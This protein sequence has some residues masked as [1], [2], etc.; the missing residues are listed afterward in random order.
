MTVNHADLSMVTARVIFDEALDGGT[1]GGALV[2]EAEADA[3]PSDIGI[4]LGGER[5]DTGDGRRNCRTNSQ[6]F[7]GDSDSPGVAVSGSSDNREG[8]GRNANSAPAAGGLLAAVRW[9]GP[10]DDLEVD[11]SV[12]G[13]AGRGRGVAPGETQVRC[14]P[15]VGTVSREAVVLVIQATAV[16]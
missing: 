7:A 4:G 16:W 8:H 12:I 10:D 5:A 13:V 1:R 14:E 11:G 15:D 2:K 9:G 3:F 6:E